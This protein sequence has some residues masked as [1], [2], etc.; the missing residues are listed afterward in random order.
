MHTWLLLRCR[1]SGAAALP[2][3]NAQELVTHSAHDQRGRLRDVLALGA[4]A[5][6][7][8]ALLCVP[9]AE[10]APYAVARWS[11]RLP[12]GAPLATCVVP[13]EPTEEHLAAAAAQLPRGA[14]LVLD[15]A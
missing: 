10:Q 9:T 2:G 7:V 15:F 3:W 13:E 11:A 5:V 8:G 12:R 6:R 14:A 1:L 4:R